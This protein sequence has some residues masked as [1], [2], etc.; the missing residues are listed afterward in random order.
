ME[1]LVA[2]LVVMLVSALVVLLAVA[3]GVRAVQKRNRVSP[4]VATPAPTTTARTATSV[5]VR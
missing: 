3:L 2:L 5:P 4:D 1:L